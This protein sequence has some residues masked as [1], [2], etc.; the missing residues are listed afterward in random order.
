MQR[1]MGFPMNHLVRVANTL[2]TSEHVQNARQI[3]RVLLQDPVESTTSFR[4][5]SAR[6]G[7]LDISRHDVNSHVCD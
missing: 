2:V 5:Q 1:R 3:L 4:L 7:T 6:E